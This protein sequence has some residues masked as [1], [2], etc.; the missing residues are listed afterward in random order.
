MKALTVFFLLVPALSG[1]APPNAPLPAN[2]SYVHSTE[3]SSAARKAPNFWGFGDGHSP[4]RSNLE[5]FRDRS[6]QITEGMWLSSMIYDAELTHAGL[7]HHKCVESNVDGPYP[8][9]G[10]L[11]LND[12]PEFAVGN[13]FSFLM[14]KYIT[15]PLMFEFPAYASVVHFRGGSHWLTQCW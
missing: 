10:E 4:L 13:A 5:I 6:W 8:S 11:Y 12:L 3:Q 15:K 14:T 7:A 2:N 9:R 1:Q